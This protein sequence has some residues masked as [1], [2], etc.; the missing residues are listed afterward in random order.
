VTISRETNVPQVAVADFF[1]SVL[2][3]SSSKVAAF[4]P[5]EVADSEGMEDAEEKES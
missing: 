4:L 5:S 1:G 3:R 2:F